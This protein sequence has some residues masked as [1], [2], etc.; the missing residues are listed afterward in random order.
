VTFN[1]TVTYMR[2]QVLVHADTDTEGAETIPI[3]LSNSV[4]AP[5]ARPTGTISIAND[6]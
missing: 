3:V 2:I 1:P 6:D 5:I 4:G